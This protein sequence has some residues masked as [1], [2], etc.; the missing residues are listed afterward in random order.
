MLQ[1]DN[2][3]KQ[4]RSSGEQQLRQFISDLE[5]AAPANLDAEAE[6]LE[7]EV[8]REIECLACANCCRSMS[9]SYSTSDIKRIA[10][11][12]R[13]SVVA[14][15][16]KWLLKNEKG[17]W[18]NRLQPCPFLNL[19][20]NKCIIYSIRPADCASFPHFTK[21]PMLDYM[22]VHKQNISFCP[23]TIKMVEKLTATFEASHKAIAP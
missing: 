10:T 22:H 11:H 3:L 17:Q 19:Q 15:K 1:L 7:P 8:W 20:T 13:L 21:K 2:D 12:F 6:R 14:F 9:P 5:Q 16:E 23:A 18:M 4:N